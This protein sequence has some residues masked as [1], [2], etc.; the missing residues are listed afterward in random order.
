MATIGN[1][2]RQENPETEGATLRL[3]DERDEAVEEA[4]SNPENPE[5]TENPEGPTQEQ[6]ANLDD[7]SSNLRECAESGRHEARALALFIGSGGG[8][9]EGYFREKKNRGMYEFAEAPELSADIAVIEERL[10]KNLPDQIKAEFP[11]AD[12]AKIDRAVFSIREGLYSMVLNGYLTGEKITSKIAQIIVKKQPGDEFQN[13]SWDK[14]KTAAFFTFRGGQAEIYLYEKFFNGSEDAQ[15]HH[16][17]HEFSH[18]LVEAGDIFS[19][20]VWTSFLEFAKLPTNENIATMEKLSPELTEMLRVLQH[21]EEHMEIWSPYI[22]A[23]IRALKANENGED[24]VRLGRELVAEMVSYYLEYGKTGETYLAR[25]L[26]SVKPGQ[27]IVYLTRRSGESEPAAFCAKYGVSGEMT[28]SQIIAALQDKEEF[29]SLF[30]ANGLWH[31][32]LS[33]T[34]SDRGANIAEGIPDYDLDYYDDFFDDSVGASSASRY[35][36]KYDGSK[37][38]AFSWEAIWGF[39]TGRKKLPQEEEATGGSMLPNVFSP[40]E[41][42]VK[43][44]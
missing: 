30:R 38:S 35:G 33:E 27:L 24:K 26:Q 11:E 9:T 28:S 40:K 16:I 34:F 31:K 39:L 23:R 36:Y 21:P 1:T 20:E 19:P 6:Q 15:A 14:S 25:R 12:Q 17:R 22:Q 3:A 37:P 8:S 7:V 42:P 43:Y 10:I 5:E 13:E 29:A 41:A 18:I 2:N 44:D 4:E 32:K